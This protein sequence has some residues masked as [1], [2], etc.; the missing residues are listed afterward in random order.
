VVH[1]QPNAAEIWLPQWRGK[2]DLSFTVKTT[3]RKD[4]GIYF[5]LRAKDNVFCPAPE[6]KAGTAWKYDCL[7]LYFDSRARGKTGTL[8]SCGMDQVVIIPQAGESVAPCKVWYGLEGLNQVD[9][10]CVGR[11]TADGYLIEGKVT[12][13][14]KSSFRVKGGS[15]FRM[16]FM[17]DDADSLDAKLLRKA[18]MA[19]HGDF[20]NYRNSDVWGRYELSLDGK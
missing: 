19:L 20:G 9:V 8:L 4:D 17:L 5:L 11:K 1:G 2:D 10:Q 16:D 14:A 7:E 18:A 3:W 15:Q 13:N 12:P 6:D